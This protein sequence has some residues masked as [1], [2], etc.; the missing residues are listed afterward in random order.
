MLNENEL[1]IKIIAVDEIYKFIVLSFFLFE[2]VKMLKKINN[3]FWDHKNYVCHIRKILA[4][5]YGVK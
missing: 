4:F 2:D 3:K 1:Y 5:L